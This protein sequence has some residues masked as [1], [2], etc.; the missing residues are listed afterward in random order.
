MTLRSFATTLTLVAAPFALVA[1]PAIAQLGQSEGYKFLQAVKDGKG[2]EVTKFLDKPG[3]TVINTRDV[4][5]GDGALHIVVRRQDS[6]YLNYLLARGA[7]PNLKNSRG[8]T[9][10]LIASSLGAT[11]MIENLAKHGANVNLGNAS[12]ETALI[13]AVQRRDATMVRSLLDLGADPDQKDL[14]Q[15]SSARDYAH[16][17]TRTPAIAALIDAAPKKVRK[18]VSGPKL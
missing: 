10:L 16:Q 3:A 17:D 2:D 11:D 4:T 9:P 7:D 14:L 1:T 12:G 13:R 18:A 6:T 15:G 8:E 5:N